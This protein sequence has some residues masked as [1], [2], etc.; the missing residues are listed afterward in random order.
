MSKKIRKEEWEEEEEMS[1]KKIRRR[2]EM[3][4]GEQLYPPV[5]LL[6]VSSSACLRIWLTLFHSGVVVEL[7]S[8]TCIHH[9]YFF[10]LC[11]PEE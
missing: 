7:S 5:I 2:L 9:Q 1:K 8:I 10:H 11:V 4:G 3:G 6:T